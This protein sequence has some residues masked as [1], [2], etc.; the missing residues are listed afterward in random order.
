MALSQSCRIRA[1]SRRSV[2]ARGRR[3]QSASRSGWSAQ[4]LIEAEATEVVGAGRYERNDK[5]RLVPASNGAL[6]ISPA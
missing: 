3:L 5:S 6:L 4:D 2:P 1:G